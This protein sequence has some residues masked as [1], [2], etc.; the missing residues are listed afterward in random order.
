[1][2][3]GI[4]RIEDFQPRLSLVTGRRIGKLCLGNTGWKNEK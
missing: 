4:S 3:F 2:L 1:M